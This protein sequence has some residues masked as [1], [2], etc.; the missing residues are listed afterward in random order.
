MTT[1][2]FTERLSCTI[3]EACQ[4]TGLGRTKLYEEMTAGRVR[5]IH[6]GR[7][8]LVLVASLLKLVHSRVVPRARRPRG[9]AGQDD[10]AAP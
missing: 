3:A 6:V 4:A 5:T 1:I 8:R 7:R 9:G 2:P 10:L